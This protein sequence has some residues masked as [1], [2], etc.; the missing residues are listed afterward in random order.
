M[1]IIKVTIIVILLL[2]SIVSIVYA[3]ENEMYQKNQIST[4]ENLNQKDIKV[5]ILT[6][7]G[8]KSPAETTFKM[9]PDYEWIAGE[10][11]Y[12]FHV[13]VVDEKDIIKK[14]LNTNNFDLIVVPGGEVGDGQ[15]MKKCY[16]TLKNFIWKKNFAKFIKD[17]GGYYGVCGGTALITDLDLNRK[18]RSFLEYAFENSALGVTAVKS[19]YKTV[20]EPIRCKLLGLPPEYIGV[21][22]Y[23]QYAGW[24]FDPEY[25]DENP[26]GIS[27]DC[28]I[29]K[30]HPIFEDFL[31]NKRRI[32]WVGGPS[33]NVTEESDREIHILARYP[34]EEISNNKSTDIYAWNYVGGLRGFF[35]A[36]IT[37][38][39]KGYHSLMMNAYMYGE[40]WKKTDK[41][42]ETDFSN[43][44][45]MTAEIYPNE[46]KAR[47]VLSGLH[48]EFKVWWGGEIVQVEDNCKN[49]LYKGFHRWLNITPHNETIENEY[50]YN[51]WINRRSVA[52]ASNQV[53]D[54]DLPPVYGPSEVRDFE[55]SKINSE[56]FLI[57]GNSETSD[58]VISLRLYYRHRP[59]NETCWSEWEYYCTDSY[60]SDGWS[61][62]FNTTFAKGIG[63]YQFYSIRHVIFGN[64]ELIEKAPPGADAEILIN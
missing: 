27:L 28:K 36:I 34:I 37:N 45:A 6:V 14:K 3:N 8:I 57:Y 1:R 16:P 5:A 52:W 43:Q 4:I 21:G 22:A 10:T 55:K 42:I 46:N 64:E 32:C 18:P 51:Y 23:P 29:L 9:L 26:V 40:D 54:L 48:P 56:E 11:K 25:L 35:K 44:P 62:N 41:L 13:Q 31:E 15:A 61:W 33:L 12:R 7:K 49:N 19:H 63:Y 53:N 20:G 39:G 38:L 47:I 17:G 2:S 58:G 50:E 24:N 60:E 59:N 30:D